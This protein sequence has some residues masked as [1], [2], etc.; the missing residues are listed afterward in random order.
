MNSRRGVTLAILIGIAGISGCG[1]SSTSSSSSGIS[2]AA[3]RAQVSQI[4]L[5]NNNQIKALPTSVETSVAGL[6]K[7]LSI[8]ETSFVRIKQIE[9]PSSIKSSVDAWL[10][11]VGQSEQTAIEL[12]AAV[13]AN[14][15]KKIQ[16]LT[17]KGDATAARTKAD[18]RALG[19]PDC[20]QNAEPSGH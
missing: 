20:A 13:K 14:D 2:I 5:S 6:N 7:L 18:A 11:E 16:S 12:V 9:P 15:Q 1:S 17:T 8:A 4:C 3:Y 19:S 10:A